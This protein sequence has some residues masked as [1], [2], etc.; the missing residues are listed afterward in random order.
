MPNG[1][2]DKVNTAKSVLA[3]ANKKFPSPV[4]APAPAPIAKSMGVRPPTR[5]SGGPSLL[6]AKPQTG[7]EASDIASGLKWNAEQSRAAGSTLGQ[8]KDGGKVPKTGKYK[9]HKGETVL[10]AD[11]GKDIMKKSDMGMSAMAGLGSKKSKKKKM[12]MSIESS[13]NDGYIT[14]HHAEGDE[15]EPM[16]K[17]ETHVHPNMDALMKHVKDTM[18]G[19]EPESAGEEA[20]EQ[21]PASPAP[22][23]MPPASA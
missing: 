16:S 9:L 5:P 18:G 15:K 10:T 8:F 13:D 12:R 14:R 11:E 20:A 6:D 7:K 3:G 2:Q 22:G 19:D 23:G 17:E 1:I 21:A 4:A